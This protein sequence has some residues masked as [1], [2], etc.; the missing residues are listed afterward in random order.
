MDTGVL[1]IPVDGR[2]ELGDLDNFAEAMRLSYAYFYVLAE[3]TE[4]DDDRVRL[5][6]SRYFWSGSYEGDEFV[7]KLYFAIPEEGRPYIRRFSYASP[8]VVEIGAAIPALMLLAK[9][10]QCWI[11]TGEQGF[12]L[13]Q[14]IDT[15]FRDR[16]LR[17]IPK[18]FDLDLLSPK[19]ID[20]ARELCFELG[21]NLG[22]SDKEIERTL[23]LTGNPISGLKLMA[24]C[25]HESERLGR[26]D[27]GGK[28]KMSDAKISGADRAA[29]EPRPTVTLPSRKPRAPKD[30]S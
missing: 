9:C 10:V 17:R 5:L 6:M 14:E 2:W 12:K 29:R 4:K 3:D 16:K 19:D 26:L 27:R 24:Q 11:K 25:V 7:D 28:A 23:Q 15:Y 22:M 20:R 30:A 13:Y 21:G 8:G 18:S 1:T